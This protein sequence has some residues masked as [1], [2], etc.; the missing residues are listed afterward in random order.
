MSRTYTPNQY[1]FNTAYNQR[2]LHQN[3]QDSKVYLSRTSNY[4]LKAI[5]DDL[6]LSGLDLQIDDNIDVDTISITILP[7]LLIQD[8]TLIELTDPTTLTLNLRPYDQSSGYIIVYTSYQ[9]QNSTLENNL[10]LKMSYITTNGTNIQPSTDIWDP[11]YN[12]ILLY[13]F[14]FTKLPQ[15]TLTLI[16]EPNFTIYNTPYYLKGQTNFT[17][18]S[19]QILDHASNSSTYGYATT[20]NAGH[21]RIGSNLSI[22]NGTLSVQEASQSSAGAVKLATTE[23]AILMESSSLALTPA[24]LRQMILNL[25]DIEIQVTDPGIT[26][27]TALIL[28]S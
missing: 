24:S 21:I 8:T 20:N 27:G 19:T 6:V 28:A 10:Q 3:T 12:R 7:G 1:Q 18:F 5:G 26:L 4:L 17:N 15:A 14:S 13:R 9:Y 25:K 22:S 2:I 23:E 11:N 16:E